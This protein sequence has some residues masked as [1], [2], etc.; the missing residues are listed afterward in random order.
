MEKLPESTS[1]TEL[2]RRVRALNND[3]S[4]HG[5]LVQMPLPSHISEAAV[6][7]AIDY[8]KDVDG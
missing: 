4:V 3:Y 6:I 5:I 2:L 7:E 1:Q 8:Q